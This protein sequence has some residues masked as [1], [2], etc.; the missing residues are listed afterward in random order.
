MDKYNSFIPRLFQPLP[1]RGDWAITLTAK[2]TYYTCD[3]KDVPIKW[4]NHENAHKVQIL[5]DGVV[6]YFNYLYWNLR[7]GYENN[8]YEVEARRY[9]DGT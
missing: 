5:R 1:W 7:Y 8:P 2:T 6:F 3:M 9:A 4:F